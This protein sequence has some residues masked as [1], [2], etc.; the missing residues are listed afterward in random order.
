MDGCYVTIY[1]NSNYEGK[2]L[3]LDGPAEFANLKNLPGD[4]QDWGDKIG[5]L[6]VGPHATV[7]AWEDENFGDT[8]INFTP[9]QNVS[10]LGELGMGDDIDSI[11]IYPA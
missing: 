11:K 2:S 10:D 4:N 3:R 8:E 9:G 5:S 7:K 1:E 6:I